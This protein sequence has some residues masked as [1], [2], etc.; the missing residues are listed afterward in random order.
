MNIGSIFSL[1]VPV[2]YR[3]LVGIFCGNLVYIFPFWYAAPRKIWQ[4]WTPQKKTDFFSFFPDGSKKKFCVKTLDAKYVIYGNSSCVGKRGMA[5]WLPAATVL[6]LFR[7]VRLQNRLGSIS[8]L[9]LKCFYP[10]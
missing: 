10:S 6:N 2:L 9:I 8:V 3:H 4:P 7:G 5:L 1:Y